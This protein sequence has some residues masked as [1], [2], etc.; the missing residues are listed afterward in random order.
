LRSHGGLSFGDTNVGL[1]VSHSSIHRRTVKSPVAT[2]QV[3]P[4]IL[5]ALGIEPSELQA[6]KRAGA[7]VLPFLFNE[8]DDE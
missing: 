1:I 7:Q 8:S 4:S 6:V 3:A 5:K 2:S